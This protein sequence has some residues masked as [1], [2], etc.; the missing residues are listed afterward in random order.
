MD[1]PNNPIWLQEKDVAELINLRDAINALEAGLRTEAR[2]E[3]R[4]MN[5]TQLVWP[6]GQTMHALG[7][8]SGA[9]GI[10]GTKTWTH[11]KNGAIPLLILWDL[12]DGRLL[13]VIEAFALGQ[14][15]TAAISGLAARWMAEESAEELAL[16]GTGKQAMP[17]VFAVLAVRPIRR[18]RVY[19]P[20]AEN[21]IA[22]ADRLRKLLPD[23]DI[24]AAGSV[25]E[26]VENSS[27]ITLVTRAREPFL[28]ASMILSGAHINAVGAI[29]PEREEFF[30]DVFER[31]GLVVADNIQSTKRFSNEFIRFY[32]D[33]DRWSEVKSMGEVINAGIGRPENCDISLFK[34]MGQGLL[35]L[36]VGI[37]ILHRAQ[38]E[39]RGMVLEKPTRVAPR[40]VD[41]E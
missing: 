29:A 17:Q 3:S 23:M 2:D 10:S 11:T 40:L 41:D 4:S 27:I 39:N 13:A 24:V 37:E 8:I 7:A 26:A 32:G 30:Q 14:L 38:L 31:A 9:E 22:F 16:I 18:I 36:S 20:T 33:T 28:Y 35:D 19:S 34:A 12:E 25:E 5:T 21:R 6:E 1:K 15:K